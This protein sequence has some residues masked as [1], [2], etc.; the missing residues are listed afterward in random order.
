MQLDELRVSN[1]AAL[2]T[3]VEGVARQ[4]LAGLRS[5]EQQAREGLARA[6][7]ESVEE[8]NARIAHASRAWVDQTLGVLEGRAQTAIEGFTRKTEQNLS[9]VFSSA[10]AD[11]ADNLR[12]RLLGIAPEKTG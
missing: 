3:E 4:A 10:L 1:A 9:V 8:Y 2:R 5:L 6:T 12:A 7:D 11:F